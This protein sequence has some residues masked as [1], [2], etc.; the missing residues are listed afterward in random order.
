M[1]K[2]VYVITDEVGLHA[3]PAGLLVKEAKNYESTITLHCNGKSAAAN[4]LMAVMG[5]G[6]KHGDTVEVTVEGS[7]EDTAFDAMETFFREHF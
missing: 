1:K 4:K 7:D 6:V 5:M 3:R 2:F